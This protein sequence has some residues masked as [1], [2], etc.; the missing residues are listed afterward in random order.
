MRYLAVLFLMVLG[1]TLAGEP[2][3][4]L[5]DG[6]ESVADYAKKVNLPPTQTLD[7]GNGVKLELVL[8]PAGKFIMGTPAPIPVD[9]DGFRKKIMTGQA[10]LAVSGIVLLALLAV[11][12][13][14]AIRKRQR[15]TFSLLWLLAMTALAGVAVFGGVHWWQ[16]VK[17]LE[18]ATA[19]F[20]ATVRRYGAA[21][22]NEKPA[23]QVALTKPFFMGKFAVTQ[24]Q[25][26]QL[27]GENPSIFKGKGNPVERVSWDDA[28]AF[29]KMLTEKTKQAVQLPTEAQWEYACRAGT[30][31]TYYSGDTEA[32]LAR[33]AWYTGNSKSTTHPVGQKDPNAFGLYDMHGNVMQWCQDW[34]GENYYKK[35]EAENPH[36]PV[37]SDRRV[38]RGS[39]CSDIRFCRSANRF[40]AGAD[41]V[42]NMGGFRVVVEPALTT[43]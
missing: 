7:L 42:S 14:R 10:L 40:G 25:Y 13:I 5:W 8:I 26:E 28:Q 21:A 37:Q 33:V 38:L 6:Q 35:S 20:H 27:T 23:H 9:E 15:P 3:Y 41:N 43:P 31:T 19:E 17:G 11:V 22:D 39:R 24:E 34:Y 4:P 12:V 36:G 18:M 1:T 32:D 29:C 2:Q 30:A 16:S